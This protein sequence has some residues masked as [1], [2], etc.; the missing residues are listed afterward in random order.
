VPAV[1]EGLEADD[2]RLVIGVQ[3]HPERIESTPP[4]FEGL[5]R[6]FVEACRREEPAPA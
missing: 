2:D 5:W 1:V 3:C 6:A 4:E